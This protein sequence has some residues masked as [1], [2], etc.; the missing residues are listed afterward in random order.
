[1]FG[2]GTV[3]R[4][5][6]ARI[7]RAERKEGGVM[8]EYIAKVTRVIDGDTIEVEIDLGFKI[9]HTTILRLSGINAPELRTPEGVA[10]KAWLVQRIEGKSVAVRTFKDKKEKYGRYLALVEYHDPKYDNQWLCVNSVM[11]VEGMAVKM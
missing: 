7:H 3:D 5:T 9:K 10:A 1:M 2:V 11:V 6:N 8:Y 4:K